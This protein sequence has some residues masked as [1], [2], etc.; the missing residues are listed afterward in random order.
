MLVANASQAKSVCGSDRP[1]T[2]LRSIESMTLCEIALKNEQKL[3]ISSRTFS[4]RTPLIA[5]ARSCVM[6]TW[7]SWAFKQLMLNFESFMFAI[8]LIF[9]EYSIG[10]FSSW[11]NRK[12][13]SF[14][15]VS[16]DH[17]ATGTLFLSSGSVKGCSSALTPIASKSIRH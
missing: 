15:F 5:I 11:K 9:D 1:T 13:L 6:I 10:T 8:F 14:Y 16:N 17:D 4:G 7:Q 2:F 12:S 3:M